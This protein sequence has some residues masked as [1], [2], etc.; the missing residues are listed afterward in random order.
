[1]TAYAASY[2]LREALGRQFV[3]EA[4]ILLGPAFFFGNV[5]LISQQYN[6]EAHVSWAFLALF[7]V[8]LPLPYL[9]NSRM[10]TVW[11]AAAFLAGLLAESN[12]NASYRHGSLTTAAAPSHC[13]A[14]SN[15]FHIKKP[16]Q[17]AP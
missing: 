17:I 8:L 6:V 16:F 7:A 12:R 14:C 1:M 11:V 9:F 10:F 3:G 2:W 15:A 5:T 4:L 13:C